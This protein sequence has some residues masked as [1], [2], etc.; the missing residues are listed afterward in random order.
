MDYQYDW[1]IKRVY[2]LRELLDA[3]LDTE[4]KQLNFVKSI[5]KVLHNS[6]SYMDK[7]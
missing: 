5:K 7:G 6:C 1:S 4:T 2:L 3:Q